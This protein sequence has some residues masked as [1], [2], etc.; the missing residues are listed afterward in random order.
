MNLLLR[1][2]PTVVFSNEVEEV[3]LPSKVFVTNCRAREPNINK[4]LTGMGWV[5]VWHQ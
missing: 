1:W 5:T 2:E 3:C 4:K